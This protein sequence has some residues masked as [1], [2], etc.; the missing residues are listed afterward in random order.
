MSSGETSTEQTIGLPLAPHAITKSPRT[1]LHTCAEMFAS[2]CHTS[3]IADK[4]TSFSCYSK[5]DH[6]D[7]LTRRWLDTHYKIN[8]TVLISDLK[9]S[10]TLNENASSGNIYLY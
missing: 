8:E 1:D 10:R 4:V 3:A 5:W 2:S 9:P 7:T 6:F